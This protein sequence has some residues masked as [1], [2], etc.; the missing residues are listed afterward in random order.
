MQA[1]AHVQP[2]SERSFQAT[3]ERSVLL[4][5]LSHSQG[6]V[7]KRSTVPILSHVLLEARGDQLTLTA[8]DLEIAIIESIAA[9]ITGQ[10]KATVS[11]G[12]LFDIVRK[13]KD[14]A[15]VVLNYQAEQQRMV[16]ASGKSQFTLPCLGSAEFPAITNVRQPHHFMISAHILRDLLDRTRFAMS[17]EE[18]RYYLNGIY[19]HAYQGAELRAVATDGHRL[20]Q[21]STMLPSGAESMPGVILS[22]KTVNEVL[23]VLS[24]E[25]LDVEIFL[26]ETQISFK[27]SET[28]LTSRLIDGTFPDY[29]KVIP[30]DNPYMLMLDMDVFAEA[31]DRVATIASEKGRG[32]K[33]SFKNNLLILTANSH[34]AGSAHEEI[35][36]DYSSV[37]LD[38]GFNARYLL[39]VAQQLKGEN[40]TFMLGENGSPA[41]VKNCTEDGALYVLMPMR[42]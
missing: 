14:G 20:A 27:F 37:P 39:D 10:G 15:D 16:I 7:E 24:E 19:L 35:E 13:L 34:E 41:L 36:I 29:E 6:V 42:V 33:L 18:T 12:M 28:Y 31:V 2:Q 23:K 32:V 25:I 4:R 11:A 1:A 9:S 21:M 38:L 26:S 17:T 40:A 30:H 3:I 22:R 8:T 5:A